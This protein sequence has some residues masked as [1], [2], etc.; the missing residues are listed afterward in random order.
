MRRY[1]VKQ[2]QAFIRDW[3]T[4]DIV[5]DEVLEILQHE[6]PTKKEETGILI[7]HKIVEILCREA[8]KGGV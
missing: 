5:C 1:T 2:I 8:E 7:R 4:S 3:V 6:D